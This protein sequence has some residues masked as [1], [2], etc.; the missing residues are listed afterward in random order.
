MILLETELSRN[1]QKGLDNFFTPEIK[2]IG[3]IFFIII[4]IYI[5]FGNKVK[6]SIKKLY[7]KMIYKKYDKNNK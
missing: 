6:S 3:I 2:I 5:L 4:L 1:I 7:Y